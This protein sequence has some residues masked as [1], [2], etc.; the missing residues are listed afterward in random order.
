MPATKLKQFLDSHGVR[1][2]SVQ[3]SPAFTAT[4]VAE[5]VHV[6]VSDF[7]KTIIV[8]VNGQMAM[9]VLP[10]NRKIVLADL[11][12][13]VGTRNVELATEAEFMGRFPDCEVGAMPPFG[14]LYG[15]AV[16]MAANITDHTKITFNAG[17][18][19]D[20]ITMDLD[21]Y[22]ELARPIILDFVTT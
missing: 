20:V 11:R 9:V 5:S 10:A 18:H 8:K 16:Y 21:D 3:H 17:T 14:H 2:V 22:L 6:D 1:Y 7:A 13:M 19:R 4:E 15:L 12:D